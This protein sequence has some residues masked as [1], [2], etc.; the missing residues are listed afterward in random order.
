M[1]SVF[2]KLCLSGSD[3]GLALGGVENRTIGGEI[4]QEVGHEPR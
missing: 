4:S 3:E 1:N 2:A